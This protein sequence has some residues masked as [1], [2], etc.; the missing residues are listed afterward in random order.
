VEETI[1]FTF[2]F[3]F[4][5]ITLSVTLIVWR[6]FRYKETLAMIEQGLIPSERA[7]KQ[8]AKRNNGKGLLA[9]G[10]GITAFGLA[11]LCAVFPLMWTR[12]DWILMGPVHLPGL[13]VLFMGIALI[14]IYFVTRPEPDDKAAKEIRT[15]DE[16]DELPA[17]LVSD[18]P[19]VELDDK[20][21]SEE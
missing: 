5:V 1:I 10:I 19:A 3:T 11:L 9:W 12:K 21:P 8:T 7:K 16:F 15:P 6:W 13:L 14:I 2:I 4:F 18:Q 20:G 17:S